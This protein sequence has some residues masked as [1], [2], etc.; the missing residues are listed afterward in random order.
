MPI[1]G[2]PCRNQSRP[3]VAQ[4]LDSLPYVY[5]GLGLVEPRARLASLLSQVLPGDLNGFLFPSSG[6]EANEAAIRIARQFTGRSKILTR[7]RSYHGGTATALVGHGRL[8][9]ELY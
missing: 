2:T 7:Y 4:Q 6:A 9:E 8:S 3:P 1:W 5:G